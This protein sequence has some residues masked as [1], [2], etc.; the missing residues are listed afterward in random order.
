ASGI[1]NSSHAAIRRNRHLRRSQKAGSVQLPI[2]EA[3]IQKVIYSGGPKHGTLALRLPEQGQS[4][5]CRVVVQGDA[6][7]L[8]KGK[9]ALADAFERRFHSWSAP[10]KNKRPGLLHPSVRI[11]V[12]NGSPPEQILAADMDN[13]PRALLDGGGQA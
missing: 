9:P 13:R 1:D 12:R 4:S 2:D 11:I 8:S 5:A 6:Q 10:E 7:P 3:A